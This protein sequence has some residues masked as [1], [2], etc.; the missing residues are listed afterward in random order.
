MPQRVCVTLNP[1]EASMLDDV[2]NWR[3]ENEQEAMA[4]ALRSYYAECEK[5]APK[6]ARRAPLP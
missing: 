1:A 3:G 6:R 5:M 4:R 2:C